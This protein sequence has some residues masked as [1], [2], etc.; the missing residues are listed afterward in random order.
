VGGV[1]AWSAS[2]LV[3]GCLLVSA[4]TASTRGTPVASSTTRPGSTPRTTTFAA[5][6]E[7]VTTWHRTRATIVYR[8]QRQR[9]GQPISAHQCLREMVIERSEI[10]MGLRRCDPSGTVTL[11]WDPPRRWRIDSTEAG[12]TTTAIVVASTGV[13]CLRRL[14]GRVSC[15]SRPARA[16]VR[17]VAFHELLADVRGTSRSIGLDADGRVIAWNDEVA[18][19]PVRCFERRDG[20]S[21]ATWC[22]GN[23]GALLSM[24]LRRPGRLPTIVEAERV[25][26]EVPAG[27]FVPPTS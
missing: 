23:G 11:V 15:R 8:T 26:S 12:E 18:G 4:C 22:F 16:L 1:R 17:A 20:A 24:T 6:R 14:G 2:F 21:A 13:L 5:L 10:P 25:S 9:P 27:S 19:A 7:A 3:I